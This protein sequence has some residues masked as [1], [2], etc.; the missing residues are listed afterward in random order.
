MKKYIFTII[1][2]A[3]LLISAIFYYR[4][5]KSVILYRQFESPN[6]DF[7]IKVFMYPRRFHPP[8]DSGGGRGYVQ[9]VNTRT[10]NILKEKETDMVMVIET[11]R[12]Q[13]DAVNIKL[14]ADWKL[15]N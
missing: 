4:R 14:F 9:L 2:L 11:V 7:A 6:D 13:E 5:D 3:L 12:W 15:P 8:G 10:G 1:I